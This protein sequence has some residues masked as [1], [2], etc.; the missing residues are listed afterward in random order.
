MAA[1]ALLDELDLSEGKLGRCAAVLGRLR[2]W[3]SGKQRRLR[4]FAAPEP[5]GDDPIRILVL[6]RGAAWRGRSLG[7]VSPAIANLN[8]DILLAINRVSDRRCHDVASGL[9]RLQHLAAV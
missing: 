5:E 6:G 2:K 9:N 8:G 1:R 7:N 4:H 3:H